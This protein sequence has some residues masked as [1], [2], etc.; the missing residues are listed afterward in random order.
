MYVY[1]RSDGDTEIPFEFKL[2][3][4]TGQPLYETYHGV[5]VNIQYLLKADMPRPLLAKNL[6]KT[7]EFIV[8]VKVNDPRKVLY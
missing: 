5:F 1:T 7:L 3:S 2:E 6:Q 8:E 4:S